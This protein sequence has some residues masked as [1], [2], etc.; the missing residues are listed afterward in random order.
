M[1]QFIIVTGE[2]SIERP[3]GIEL[4]PVEK[5]SFA[6]RTASHLLSDYR[7]QLSKVVGQESGEAD[8]LIDDIYNTSSAGDPLVEPPLLQFLRTLVAQGH[9]VVCWYGDDV[10]NVPVFRTW[11]AFA[12][13]VLRDANEQ[14]PEVYAVVEPKAPA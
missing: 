9:S 2:P 8:R 4:R 11:E 12:E 13:A 14:P 5:D 10:S 1:T 7:G 6:A 3:S